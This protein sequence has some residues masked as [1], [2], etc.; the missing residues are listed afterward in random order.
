MED[1]ANDDE[2]PKKEDLDAEA[3]SDDI[4]PKRLIPIAI[5]GSQNPSAL[6]LD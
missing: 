1:A 2:E 3:S 4:L 6:K 5:T